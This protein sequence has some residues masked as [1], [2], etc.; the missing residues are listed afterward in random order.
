M[1]TGRL[2][3]FSDGV[4][5]VAITL[6]A[7]NLP[8]PPS[9]RTLPV[10]APY[11]AQHWPSFAAFAVS[12]VTIGI[13]WM[14]H[15]AMVRRLSSAD[16][17]ILFLNVLLLMTVC[18]LPFT[19]A[20]MAQYL[21]SPHGERLAAAIWAGSFLVMGSTFLAVQWHLMVVKTHLL[22]K[23][24]TPEMRR[25]VLRRNA[26]GVFPYAIETAAAALTPYITLAI[27]GLVA[28]FYA[29]PGTTDLDLQAD[30]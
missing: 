25:A 30:S 1:S 3:A 13:I 15:H 10:L 14:N 4:I 29:L 2:E 28:A 27:C 20:L 8:L 16:M 11:L 7:L 9:T 26:A 6:L 21:R 19:T 24:L 18:V 5:A 23:R 17:E 22:D 12:F